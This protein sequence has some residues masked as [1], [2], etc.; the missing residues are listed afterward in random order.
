MLS[1]IMQSI[2]SV[3]HELTLGISIL[4]HAVI[5]P[6]MTS[7]WQEIHAHR[8]IRARYKEGMFFEKILTPYA[9]EIFGQGMIHS[10][11][12][13]YIEVVSMNGKESLSFHL[14]EFDRC[15]VLTS[16]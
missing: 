11:S 16:E 2:G 8:R 14:L 7:V 4:A 1:A 12:R 9:A 5:A 15:F 10:I 13:F 6:A 3:S